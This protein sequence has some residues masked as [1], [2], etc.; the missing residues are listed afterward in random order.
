MKR[1]IAKWILGL[2][3]ARRQ[4]A[5]G[6][7]M[8][9]SLAEGFKSAL[10]FVEETEKSLVSHKSL[11]ETLYQKNWEITKYELPKLDEDITRHD[12]LIRQLFVKNRAL[13]EQY[14]LLEKLF[15]EQQAH[16]AP[17]PKAKA[18]AK[19]RRHAPR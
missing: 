15:S 14:K 17:K 13:E 1:F 19:G 11:I 8:D 4:N 9:S 7:F 16:I 6:E 2:P 3:L 18:K 5:Q 10:D 12:Q